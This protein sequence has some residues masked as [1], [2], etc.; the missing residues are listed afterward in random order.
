MKRRRNIFVTDDAFSPIRINEVITGP[1]GPTGETG[2]TGPSGPTGEK[3][4]IG[5]TGFVCPTGP[6]GGVG[7]TGQTGLIGPTGPQGQIG[8]G[9][10]TGPTGPQGNTGSPGP[11][12]IGA[13]GPTGATGSIG[14]TGAT[15]PVGFTGT[16]GNV[17]FTGPTGEIGPTGA[18]GATG[19]IGATGPIGLT[20]TTGPIGP[21]GATGEIGAT[22]AQVI[23]TPVQFQGTITGPFVVPT[24]PTL[25]S[26]YTESFS[27]PI[28]DPVAGTFTPTGSAGTTSI[29][30]ISFT[31]NLV[32]NDVE[33][34]SL[35]LS[36]SKLPAQTGST[37]Y[38]Q[39]GDSGGT[40][41]PFR[42]LVNYNIIF[43]F[44]NSFSYAIRVVSSPSPSAVSTLTNI[45]FRGIFLG[46]L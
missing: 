3:G 31:A 36:L 18:M 14:F 25:I 27:D 15:G 40:I 43:Q 44:E 20:G 19:L 41:I 6:S 16:T 29:F 45:S 22:G 42:F 13:T 39:A 35:F 24:T 38:F 7:A 8:Q 33:R 26:G 30:Y 4:A 9:G 37:K 12:P 28:F 34:S 1:I 11:S 10:E 17:G 23:L 46:Q 2:P 5:P 32:T 21:I